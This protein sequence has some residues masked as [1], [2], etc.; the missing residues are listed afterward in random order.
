MVVHLR[1]SSF[2]SSVYSRTV[3]TRPSQACLPSAIQSVLLPLETAKWYFYIHGLAII[4]LIYTYIY[5]YKCIGSY[6]YGNP[7]RLRKPKVPL[8]LVDILAISV[9]YRST[10]Y[11]QPLFFLLHPLHDLASALS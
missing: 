7:N 8:E 2:D 6:H 5:I 9:T 4:R 10:D 1:G 11:K 3:E